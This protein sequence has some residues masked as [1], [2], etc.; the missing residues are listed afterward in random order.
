MREIKNIKPLHMVEI[1]T[2]S[3]V[4]RGILLERPELMDKKYIVI[5][6][7]S[8]YNIGIKKDRIIEIKDFGE[9]KKEKLNKR[10]R[11]NLRDD[12]PVVS[13]IATGGTIA[14]RVDYLTGGVHSAFSAEELISAVP[15]LNSIAYIHG[16]QIFNKFS[17]NMQPE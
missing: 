13:I 4:Y 7:D 12:M 8:G 17:E 14:S 10:Q 1:K 6:L 9:I 15:E 11:Y 3:K 5:K 16:R 2:E